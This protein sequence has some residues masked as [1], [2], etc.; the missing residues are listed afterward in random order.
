MID[1]TSFMPGSTAKH[2]TLV[3]N[4]RVTGKT[5]QKAR[6]RLSERFMESEMTTESPDG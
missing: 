4:R 6:T 2:F 3:F 1:L 5:S